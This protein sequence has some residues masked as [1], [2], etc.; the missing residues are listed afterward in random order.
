MQT[1]AV[2]LLSKAAALC[3]DDTRL[4]RVVPYLLVRHL[5]QSLLIQPNLMTV[6]GAALVPFCYPQP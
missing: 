6:S 3:D 5:A 2:A 1:R 4:Q